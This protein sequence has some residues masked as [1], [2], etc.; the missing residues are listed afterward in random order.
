[1]TYNNKYE[2]DTYEVY[3][4]DEEENFDDYYSEYDSDNQSF[5]HYDDEDSNL[6]DKYETIQ[7]ETLTLSRRS[8]SDKIHFHTAFKFEKT[9]SEKVEKYF[10]KI[11]IEEKKAASKI[12]RFV[13]KLLERWEERRLWLKAIRAKL[14]KEPRATRIKREKEAKEAKELERREKEA[15]ELEEKK[16][17][18]LAKPPRVPTTLRKSTLPFSH[19]RKGGGKGRR[20]PVRSGSE[21]DQRLKNVVKARRSRRR[22]EKKEVKK[23]EEKK[24][25]ESFASMSSTEIQ[26]LSDR[27]AFQKDYI[28]HDVDFSDET[29]KQR[30]LEQIELEEAELSYARNTVAK[31][32]QGINNRDEAASI[33]TKL[34]RGYLI[35]LRMKKFNEN[36]RR[37]Q[38]KQTQLPKKDITKF[39]VVTRKRK[40]KKNTLTPEQQIYQSLFKTT[41]KK[42]EYK[43]MSGKQ[44]L[45]DKKQM[46]KSLLRSRLCRSIETG[47][48]CPHGKNCRFAHS[49]DEIELVDCYFGHSCNRVSITTNGVYKNMRNCNKCTYKHP[50]E[51][52]NNYCTRIGL[53]IPAAKVEVKTATTSK[54]EVKTTAKVEVT[55]PWKKKKKISSNPW[56]KQSSII[57]H[58]MKKLMEEEMDKNSEWNTVNYTKKVIVIKKQKTKEI[59]CRSVGTGKPC[60]HGS[61]CRFAHP[62][63]TTTK[64]TKEIICRSV[65]TGKPCPH[66]S[67]CRF[68]HQKN[69]TTTKT[70]ITNPWKVK[71]KVIAKKSILCN[72]ICTGKPCP[73][74][75]CRFLH[76]STRK[77]DDRIIIKLPIP[78]FQQTLEYVSKNNMKSVQLIAIV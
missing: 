65:G 29:E 61:K 40:R 76:L 50:D 30:Y 9:K 52:I 41:S 32:V 56:K 14:P 23:L 72:S 38:V 5:E 58:S 78:L 43:R 18:L 39:T 17:R 75:N 35:K 12:Q 2:Y 21:E 16:K 10:E 15:K 55:N 69:T 67:K 34:V 66:G 53:K 46:Q 42:D 25:A 24:R 71:S 60:P 73:H 36:G 3:C 6:Y 7:Y 44:K 22:K 62:K 1:M 45:A 13:R 54:V 68:A 64:N 74:S 19:R 48:K 31:H 77:E 63:N 57:V 26:S 11:E 37:H 28:K 8:S 49:I 20:M 33:I 51:S 27:S 4:S 47:K 70:T 59:I